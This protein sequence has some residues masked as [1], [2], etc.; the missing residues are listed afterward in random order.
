MVCENIKSDRGYN[1][2][3]EINQADFK[4]D[5]ELIGTFCLSFS[6]LCPKITFQ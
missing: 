1:K 5:H 3:Q 6:F 2:R 4:L